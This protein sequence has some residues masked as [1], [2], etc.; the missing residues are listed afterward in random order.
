MHFK[1]Q[2]PDNFRYRDVRFTILG[3][4]LRSFDIY[5]KNGML[6]Q[7]VKELIV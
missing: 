3:L 7:F 1:N 2:P 5:L 4:R 6:L